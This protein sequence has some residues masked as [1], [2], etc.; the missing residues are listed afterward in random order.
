VGQ[1]CS[2]PIDSDRSS[3]AHKIPTEKT[4]ALSPSASHVP[5]TSRLRQE[6]DLSITGSPETP[7]AP[8]LLDQTETGETPE[9]PLDPS[10]A[11]HSPEPPL[12]EQVE[13][14]I[15]SAKKTYFELHK[16][17][18]GLFEDGIS[19]SRFILC[20]ALRLQQLEHG[21]V[22]LA[23][24]T[25]DVVEFQAPLR[26]LFAEQK[27]V[28]V[29]EVRKQSYPSWD[30][31]SLEIPSSRAYSLRSLEVLGLSPSW[32]DKSSPHRYH[33]SELGFKPSETCPDYYLRP[34]P[35]SKKARSDESE[36][37]AMNIGE[38]L[39]RLELYREILP[40]VEEEASSILNL[41]TRLSKIV[42][43]YQ[44]EMTD[45]TA[46]LA[47]VTEYAASLER[48][49][50]LLDQTRKRVAISSAISAREVESILATFHAVEEIAIPPVSG[51]GVAPEEVPVRNKP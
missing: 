35:N 5:K 10:E 14:A 25:E 30:I 27:F 28:V 49:K 32:S 2:S 17:K 39:S 20:A 22:S 13:D 40:K 23:M 9:S 34:L 33:R 16:F 43:D 37:L 24:D 1:Q 18:L 7:N 6:S 46:T 29:R 36:N 12:E 51:R 4:P 3:S 50:I 19:Q 26:R 15:A 45:P 11:G 8:P 38:S 31:F 41:E 47:K 21:K 48:A 44:F 42:H